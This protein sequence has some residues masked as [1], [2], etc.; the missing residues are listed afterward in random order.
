MRRYLA[1][2]LLMLVGLALLMAMVLDL[3]EPGLAVSLLS[4]AML[5]SGVFCF[6]GAVMQNR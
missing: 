5:I 1:G 6:A 2:L 4:Y 3:I